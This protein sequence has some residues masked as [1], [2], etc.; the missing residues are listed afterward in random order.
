MAG[1]HRKAASPDQCSENYGKSAILQMVLVMVMN[2]CRIKWPLK[3]LA[4]MTNMLPR[5]G[6]WQKEEFC[7]LVLWLPPRRTLRISS[8]WMIIS[9]LHGAQTFIICR[10]K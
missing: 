1:R 4:V 3:V 5:A 10:F 6:R 9:P 8:S 2:D 7:W